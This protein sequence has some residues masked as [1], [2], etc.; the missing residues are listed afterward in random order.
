METSINTPLPVDTPK[1]METSINTPLPVDTPKPRADDDIVVT[2]SLYDEQGI[3]ELENLYYDIFDFNKGIYNKMSDENKKQYQ[4][5]LLLFYTKFTGNKT[6]PIII[7]DKGNK[8]PKVTKFSDIKLKDFHNQKLCLKKNDPKYNTLTKNE[9]EINTIWNK[10]YGPKKT[11]LF[12]KYSEHLAKMIENTKTSEKKLIG[13]LEELFI[14][15]IDPKLKKK[16]LTINPKINISSLEDIIKRTRK[17]I[18][19][20]YINCENDFQTGL[21]I[22][23]AIVKKQ[24]LEVQKKREKNLKN[25]AN[26]LSNQ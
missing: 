16:T 20:L 3:P 11:H 10:S 12:I 22:F 2:K 24:L 15:W 4:E 5:D 1:P 19:E 14:Y 25:L 9:K 8:K 18:I 17:I 23:E 7:D 6:I 26:K 13:I 21:N